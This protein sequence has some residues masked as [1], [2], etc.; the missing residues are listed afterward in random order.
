M[1]ARPS[2]T[3]GAPGPIRGFYGRRRGRRLGHIFKYI[4]KNLQIPKIF[5]DSFSWTN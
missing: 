5:L 1:T 2:W 4:L 3:L